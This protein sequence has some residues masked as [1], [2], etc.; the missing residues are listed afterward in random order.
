M[1]VFGPLAVHRR[2]RQG[3]P[4]TEIERIANVIEAGNLRVTSRNNRNM[5]HP[6]DQ[7][8]MVSSAS[9][10][11]AGHPLA[12]PLELKSELI[13]RGWERRDAARIAGWFRLKQS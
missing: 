13:R 11:A 4:M 9:V 12:S 6:D 8:R 7:A 10:A 5:G 2:E 3:Q 1:S